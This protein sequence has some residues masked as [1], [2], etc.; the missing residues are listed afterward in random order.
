MSESI[1]DALAADLREKTVGFIKHGQNLVPLAPDKHRSSEA[2][3]V[4]R[5][6]SQKQCP[7][8]VIM[9]G[10]VVKSLTMANKVSAAS[11]EPLLKAL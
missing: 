7:E 11:C 3:A 10:K 8:T 2:A 5:V 9:Q 1:C 6:R 4:S